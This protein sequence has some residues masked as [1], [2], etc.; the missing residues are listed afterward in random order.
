MAT[1]LFPSRLHIAGNTGSA[2]PEDNVSLLFGNAPP[3]L[4]GSGAGPSAPTFVRLV[5]E[6]AE[7]KQPVSLQGLTEALVTDVLTMLEARGV[8]A[9]AFQTVELM[10]SY[11]EMPLELFREIARMLF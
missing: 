5:Q 7:R 4:D 3:A 11:L 8:L 2:L 1:L 6:M 9:D 10:R